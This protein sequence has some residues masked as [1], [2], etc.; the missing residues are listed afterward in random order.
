MRRDSGPQSGSSYYL[1]KEAMRA[2]SPQAPK[3]KGKVQNSSSSH[4]LQTRKTT[5]FSKLEP[6]H[7]STNCTINKSKKHS[8]KNS[9]KKELKKYEK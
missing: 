2:K 9:K 3:S 5:S 4:I 6:N 1:R 8:A 7:S